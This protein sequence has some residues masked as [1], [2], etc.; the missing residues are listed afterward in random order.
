LCAGDENDALCAGDENDGLLRGM[1][2][3]GCGGGRE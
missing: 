3:M 2:M 1:R